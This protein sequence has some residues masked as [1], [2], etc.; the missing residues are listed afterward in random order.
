MALFTY[1]AKDEEGKLFS[2]TIQASGKSNAVTTLKSQG[3]QV[4]TIK[5]VGGINDIFS[6]R[7]QRAAA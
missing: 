1:K 2:D 6:G 4:L 3:I 7:G 5:Q